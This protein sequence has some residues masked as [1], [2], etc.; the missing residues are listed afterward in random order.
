MVDYEQGAFRRSEGKGSQTETAQG[1]VAR[2]GC[3]GGAA[4]GQTSSGAAPLALTPGTCLQGTC[5]EAA[6]EWVLLPIKWPFASRGTSVIEA[7]IWR[8]F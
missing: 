5:R 8:H 4:G 6:G 2:R 1:W 7:Q 3:G